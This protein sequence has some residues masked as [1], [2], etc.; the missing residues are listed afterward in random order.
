MSDASVGCLVGNSAVAKTADGYPGGGMPIRG[1]E[2]EE[3]F[4]GAVAAAQQGGGYTGGRMNA[5]DPSLA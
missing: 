4:R 2:V 3:I 1:E 5:G